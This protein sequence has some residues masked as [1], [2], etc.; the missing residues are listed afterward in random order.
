MKEAYTY[1]QTALQMQHLHYV[2]FRMI[3][4]D[5]LWFGP[6][7]WM[8]TRSCMNQ[9]CLWISSPFFFFF[10]ISCLFNQMKSCLCAPKLM[11]DK[12][13]STESEEKKRKEKDLFQKQILSQA[14]ML[15]QDHP[16]KSFRFSAMLLHDMNIKDSRKMRNIILNVQEAKE[17]NLGR[18]WE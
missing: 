12:S 1:S 5:H 9:I 7:N 16:Y 10:H 15:M 3:T 11:L 6:V 18:K 4:L 13:K 2:H 17:M 8:S 14:K